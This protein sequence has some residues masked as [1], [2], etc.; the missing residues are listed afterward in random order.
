M[1]AETSECQPIR[2]KHKPNEKDG[3][4]RWNG[5]R[6]EPALDKPALKPYTGPISTKASGEH[7]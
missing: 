3:T 7:W 5:S 2:G 1:H 6:W 4:M